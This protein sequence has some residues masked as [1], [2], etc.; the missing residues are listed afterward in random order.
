MSEIKNIILV[1]SWKKLV[2]SSFNEDN[3][4][5]IINFIENEKNK[6]KTC[7]PPD[8]L[9]FKALEYCSPEKVKVVILGQD[10]YHHP[11]QAHG[12]AFSVNKGVPFPPS[13]RNIFKELQDDLGLAI[14]REGNL[15]A[16]AEQGV[17]LLNAVFTVNAYEPGSHAKAGWEK[18]SDSLIEELSKSKEHLVFILWGSFAQ[19][20]ASLIDEG[21]HLIL[22]SAHPSPLSSYRG[23]FGS[24]P[25]SKANAYLK[26]HKKGAIDWSI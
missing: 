26:E 14:P 11:G 20:K 25:F 19:K 22:R 18:L 4:L 1:E 12:L 2:K 7:Y 13:L 21:K 3:M 8:N 16:W 17:L 5:E 24:K 15:E 6:G 23:F 9:I 10:P